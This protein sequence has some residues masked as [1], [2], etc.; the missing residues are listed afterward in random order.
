M[1]QLAAIWIDFREV[2]TFVDQIQV[3]S[4]HTETYQDGLQICR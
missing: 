3:G 1:Q 4:D 2:L